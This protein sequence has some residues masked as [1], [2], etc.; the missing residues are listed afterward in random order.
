MKWDIM[1]KAVGMS[2]VNFLT[3]IQTEWHCAATLAIFVVVTIFSFEMRNQA[4]QRKH[5]T[6]PPP[7]R[8]HVP[9]GEKPEWGT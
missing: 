5:P 8:V 2:L 7:P 1:R 9:E 3:R 4:D 6:P